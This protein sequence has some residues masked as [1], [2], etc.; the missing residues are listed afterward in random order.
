MSLHLSTWHCCYIK[1]SIS[2]NLE[3]SHAG[4]H[5]GEQHGAKGLVL[6]KKDMRNIIKLQV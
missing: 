1:S 2:L 4:R 6:Q 3:L 5:E